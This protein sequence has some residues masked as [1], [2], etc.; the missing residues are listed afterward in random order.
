MSELIENKDVRLTVGSDRPIRQV[1]TVVMRYGN[2]E[3]RV[4]RRTYETKSLAL[5]AA[6]I[7]DYVTGRPH[8]VESIHVYEKLDRLSLED[9][10]KQALESRG[11]PFAQLNSKDNSQC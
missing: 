2:P 3:I 7:W 4:Q 5:A 1:H 9:E 6:S 11:K 8:S 10:I